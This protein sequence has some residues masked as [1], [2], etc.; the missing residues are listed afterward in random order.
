M[1]KSNN[2][3]N[4]DPI[5]P[6]YNQLA[7]NIKKDRQTLTPELIDKIATHVRNGNYI[8]VAC[9]CE[10]IHRGT[11]HKWFKIGSQIPDGSDDIEKKFYDEM[12]RA[13]AESIRLMNDNIRLHA[14]GTYKADAFRLERRFNNKYGKRQQIEH[15]GNPLE[16]LALIID[17]SKKELKL[18]DNN[19]PEV[20]TQTDTL[21]KVGSVKDKK[22]K[23]IE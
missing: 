23:E 6:D 2:N 15:V 17:Q 21:V 3:D 20:L 13:E 18:N 19:D 4:N 11:Y 14:K 16:G 10:G 8:D 12:L 7:K 5:I 9:M 22:K 1:K